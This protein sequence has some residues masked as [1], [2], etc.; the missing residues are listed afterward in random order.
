M[1]EHVPRRARWRCDEPMF[2]LGFAWRRIEVT[3]AQVEPLPL[4]P[5]TCTTLSVL[6]SDG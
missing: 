2:Q 4:V 6:R 1:T 3:K 5:V